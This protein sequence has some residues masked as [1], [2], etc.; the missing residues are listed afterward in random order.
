MLS[1]NITELKQ[2]KTRHRDTEQNSLKLVESFRLVELIWRDLLNV[3]I[4]G[5]VSQFSSFLASR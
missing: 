4:G 5:P 1:G 3:L 2:N